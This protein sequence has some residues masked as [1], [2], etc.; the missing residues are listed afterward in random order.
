MGDQDYLFVWVSNF[1]FYDFGLFSYFDFYDFGLFSNFDF[2]EVGPLVLGA[3]LKQQEC[4]QLLEHAGVE[5]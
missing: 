3:N 5:R 4:F 1:D 2:Q